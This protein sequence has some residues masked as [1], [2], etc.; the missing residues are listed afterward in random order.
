MTPS[1]IIPRHIARSL[2]RSL[3]SAGNN[4]IGGILLAEQLRADSFRL[5]EHTVDEQA[6]T[7][8]RFRRSETQHSIAREEF[9]ERHENEFLKFNYLGE[10]HSHP[11]FAVRPSLTDCD[12]MQS[13]VGGDR[14]LPFAVLLIVRLDYWFQLRG[15]VTVFRRDYEPSPMELIFEKKAQAVRSNNV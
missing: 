12:T 8:S 4:E 6:G 7:S 3:R 9:Y 1:L 2:R 11:S 15:S 14:G 10:W 5:V 13:I